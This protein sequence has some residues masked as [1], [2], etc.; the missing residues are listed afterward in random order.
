MHVYISAGILGLNF[1]HAECILCKCARWIF[2]N[3]LTY[4]FFTF[5]LAKYLSITFRISILSSMVT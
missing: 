3:T 5:M 4:V 2:S 1:C